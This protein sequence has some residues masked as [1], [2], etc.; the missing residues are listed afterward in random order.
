MT[1]HQI[2]PG[3]K[4]PAGAPAARAPHARLHR[5]LRRFARDERGV[6][7]PM[8]IFFL[9]TLLV[10]CGVSVDVNTDDD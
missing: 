4:A 5:H 10:V 2:R 3:R 1:T 6:M 8:V 7:I 9:L